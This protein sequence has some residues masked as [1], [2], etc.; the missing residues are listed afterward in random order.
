MDSSSHHPHLCHRHHH[1]QRQNF[2]FLS[3]GRR[4]QIRLHLAAAGFP[5]L[6]DDTY[7]GVGYLRKWKRFV[8]VPC[9]TFLCFGLVRVAVGVD[10]LNLRQLD[11][12]KRPLPKGVEGT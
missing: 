10:A 8:M 5:V 6:G 2:I 3:D 12:I 11:S 7:G 9:N 1:H 4:H